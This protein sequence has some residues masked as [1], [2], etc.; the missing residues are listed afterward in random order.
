V[1]WY[2]GGGLKEHAGIQALEVELARASDRA[3]AILA[4][5]LVESRLTAFLKC[6]VQDDGRIWKDRTHSSAPLGSFAIKIDLAFLFH[7][8]TR[9][10]HSDLIVMKEYSESIC[11]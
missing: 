9:E 11:S 10:A 2:V 1:V 8:I 7:L 6:H 5:S 3:A 4:G